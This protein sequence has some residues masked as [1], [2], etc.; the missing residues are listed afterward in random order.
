VKLLI[1]NSPVVAK[2]IQDF[3]G[4]EWVVGSTRGQLKLLFKCDIWAPLPES[5]PL[6][7]LT[8]AG[9]AVIDEL[10]PLVGKAEAVYLGL[11]PDGEGEFVAWRLSQIL[12]LIN[13]QRVFFSEISKDTILKALANP[14]P[15]SL[16][17]AQAQ[18]T[19][20]VAESMVSQ[21]SPVIQALSGKNFQLSLVRLAVLGL[22]TERENQLIGGGSQANYG[23]KLLFLPDNQWERRWQVFWNPKNWLAEGETGIHDQKTAQRV[24]EIRSV[25]VASYKEGKILQKPGL[26]FTTITLLR[27]AAESLF[28]SPTKTMALALKLFETGHITYPR[29]TDHFLPE[30][31]ISDIRGLAESYGWAMTDKPRHWGS[32]SGGQEGMEC[33]RPVLI[34]EESINGSEDE[35][36]LYK[37]IRLRTIAS[38]MPDAVFSR[39]ELV[40]YTNVNGKYAFFEAEKQK[41]LTPGF[42]ALL[43]EEPESQ[44]EGADEVADNPF[45]RLDPESSLEVKNGRV[46]DKGFPAQRRFTVVSLIEEMDRLGLAK[47]SFSAP[48]LASLLKWGYVTVDPRGG[49]HSAF[50]G[51]ELQELIAAELKA[52]TLSEIQVLWNS[53]AQV[54]SGQLDW[55]KVI[56]IFHGS[57]AKSL[58]PHEVHD[59]SLCPEC[60]Q[61]L[62]KVSSQRSG[63]Y[64]TRWVCSNSNCRATFMDAGGTPGKGQ[65][66]VTFSKIKCPYCDQFLNNVTGFKNNVRYNFWSCRDR[67]NCGAS[68]QDDNG[69][70][71]QPLTRIINTSH[72]CP[73]CGSTIRRHEKMVDGQ[74]SSRWQCSNIHQCKARFKDDNGVPG[75]RVFLPDKSVVCP[76]CGLPLTHCHGRNLG[77]KF[78]YWICQEKNGCQAKFRNF[79]GAPGSRLKTVIVTKRQCPDCQSHLVLVKT[80]RDDKDLSFWVCQNRDNCGAKFEDTQGEPGARLRSCLMTKKPC[81][82]C[83]SDLYLHKGLKNGKPYSLWICSNQNCQGKYADDHGQI[84]KPLFKP[85][86]PEVTCEFCKSRLTL[87]ISRDPKVGDSWACPNH[88]CAANFENNNGVPGAFRGKSGSH[89][90]TEFVCPYCKSPIRRTIGRRA[91]DNKEYDFF[92][93]SNKLCDKKFSVANDQPVFP[94]FPRAQPAQE[95]RPQAGAPQPQTGAELAQESLASPA[96]PALALPQESLAS[97]VGLEPALPQESLASPAGF[98]PELSQESL[99]PSSDPELELAEESPPPLNE[100]DFAT[101]LAQVF[102]ELDLASELTLPQTELELAEELAQ[103]LNQLETA[104]NST[105]PQTEEESTPAAAPQVELAADPEPA[106]PQ[107]AGTRAAEE[108]RPAYRERG[109]KLKEFGLETAQPQIGPAVVLESAQPSTELIELAEP[110]QAQNPERGLKLEL[111]SILG[112]QLEPVLV[113]APPIS[114]EISPPISADSLASSQK[115]AEN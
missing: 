75:E 31:I 84:G 9:Q 79:K 107:L 38:Q 26:P 115:M 62:V 67:D 22:L 40:L 27:S 96:G 86:P 76:E 113:P 29:T 103:A 93:C 57:L 4:S 19:Y 110:A 34:G 66:L 36:N 51:Q 65:T 52:L 7:E 42:K 82:E 53:I 50:L 92:F 112:S 30:R 11:P 71:G 87:V 80:R 90:V 28:F 104:S 39:R 100:L 20:W 41:L 18:G 21:A 5:P 108:F 69:A 98:E 88:L 47:P 15:L 58:A 14:R 17:R 85:K 72:V 13:P 24:S 78:D 2:K 54:A 25:K 60:G 101:E 64:L 49:L 12:G 105:V 6:M 99:A 33:V 89:L 95:T 1:V 68:F 94:T 61:K 37:L 10:W 46:F 48:M 8:E 35:K 102:G 55:W 43:N 56:S 106:S 70:P 59:Q 77:T 73:D 45:P 81:G 114:R 109:L 3:L 91:K 63:V 74:T 16:S 97:S 23:V 44:R 83:Q 111:K 32:T